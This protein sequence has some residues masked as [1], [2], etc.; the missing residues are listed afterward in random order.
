MTAEVT[1]GSDYGQYFGP[2]N[3]PKKVS[4]NGVWYTVTRVGDHAFSGCS[5][6]T[7]VTFP[8]TITSIGNYAFSGCNAMMEMVIPGT[9]TSIGNYAFNSCSS[10]KSIVFEY[11][12]TPLKLGYGSSKGQSY[13]LF[14]DCPLLSVE[15]TRSLSYN[16]NSS[17]GYSPFAKH[18]TLKEVV[19]KNWVNT[20]SY[21]FYGCAALTSVVL[22]N[23]MTTINDYTF[24]GCKS[25]T[26]IS[27]PG[28]IT[29]EVFVWPHGHMK[30]LLYGG[31]S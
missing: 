9:I 29:K 19:Y 13:S 4:Y 14:S 1:Y 2:V 30:N 31:L 28:N 25:L 8:E 16:T 27:I 11:D 23:F 6:L 10:L 17:Y 7:S 15:I 3:I 18:P 20:G 12:P 21:L 24:Y 22:P 5:G 26:N